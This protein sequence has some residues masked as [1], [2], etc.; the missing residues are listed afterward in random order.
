MFLHVNLSAR[1]QAPDVKFPSFD[2]QRC[3]NLTMN[4]LRLVSTM[5]T[6]YDQPTFHGRKVYY[7]YIGGLYSDKI[8]N[9]ISDRGFIPIFEGCHNVNLTLRPSNTLQR[10]Y[11]YLICDYNGVPVTDDD[12]QIDLLFEIS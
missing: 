12:V 5:L 7:L 11:E 3:E 1:E 10:T 2:L 8:I 4:H 9:N 6:I